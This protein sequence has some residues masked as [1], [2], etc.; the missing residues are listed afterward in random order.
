MD[1]YVGLDVSVRETSVCVVDETGKLLKEARVPTEPEAIAS[2]LTKGGFA[3]KRVGLEA[4]PMSQWLYAELAAAGLPVICV[5]AQHMRSA[6]A[7]QRNKT[8]RNDARGIAQMMRVGLYRP[9]HV[10]TL[11]SQE[12][13]LLLTARKLLQAKMLDIEA[14]LRGALKNFGLRVGVVGKSGFRA[15]VRELVEGREGLSVVVL[16]LLEAHAAL[17]AQYDALHKRLLDLVRDDPLCRRLM[18]APGVGPVIALTFVATVD[19]PTR[20]AKSRLVGAHFG[21]TPKRY[22]SGETDRS[23]RVSKCGDEMMRT[24]LLRGRPGAAGLHEEVVQPEGLGHVRRPPARDEA[25]HRGRGA[26]VGHD[27][28]PDVAGRHRVPLGQGSRRVG[29]IAPPHGAARN[30]FR[31][32]RRG[33]V[34]QGTEGEA[35][36]L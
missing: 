8:D 9:V 3:C 15:R 14:D 12:R 30:W 21:L 2:V 27:P 29:V 10:K 18:S 28:A 17:Q 24:A 25:R 31:P 11:P 23:G 7:A 33:G 36:S 22:A 16:A 20:F 6:L 32:V 34:P 13:R 35:S 1:H 19:I 26:Q 5:E 4:G